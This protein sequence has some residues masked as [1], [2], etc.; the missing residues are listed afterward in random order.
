MSSLR[1]CGPRGALDSKYVYLNFTG[2]R[3]AWLASVFNLMKHIPLETAAPRSSLPSQITI[4]VP[5]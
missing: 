5:A 3:T 1:L 2:L 4:C